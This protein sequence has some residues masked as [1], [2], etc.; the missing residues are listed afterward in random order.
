[1]PIQHNI[2]QSPSS[3]AAHRQ[4]LENLRR[5]AKSL[6]NQDSIPGGGTVYHE[7]MHHDQESA[8]VPQS[9]PDQLA[10]SEHQ[11]NLINSLFCNCLPNV[12][13]PFA[14]SSNIISFGW[15]VIKRNTGSN[16][17]CH[18]ADRTWWK[19]FET[20]RRFLEFR[21]NFQSPAQLQKPKKNAQ[22]EV[23]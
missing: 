20:S 3:A 13:G 22:N 16:I 12:Y 4:R 19:H 6:Q 21:T 11:W 14:R 17:S 5:E 1:M 9:C 18:P 7:L 15:R 2:W 8:A 23:P 10:T